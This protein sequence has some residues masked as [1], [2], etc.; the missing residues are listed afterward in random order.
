MVLLIFQ[1]WVWFQLCNI[2]VF[3]LTFSLLRGVRANGLS[4]GSSLELGFSPLLR[5]VNHFPKRAH[6]SVNDAASSS[7]FDV[8]PSQASFLKLYSE[9][10]LSQELFSFITSQQPTNTALQAFLQAE[11]EEGIVD[12]EALATRLRNLRRMRKHALKREQTKQLHDNLPTSL[13][14]MK[15]DAM[16][17]VLG[18][19]YFLPGQQIVADSVAKLDDD[20]VRI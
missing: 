2:L 10:F 6:S 17:K 15:R 3:F 1:F 12:P 18:D 13:E 19:I 5:S 7:V 9:P 11:E 16:I 14:E 4:S 8:V 20:Q